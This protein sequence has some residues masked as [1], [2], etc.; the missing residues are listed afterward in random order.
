MSAETNKC[1]AKN[2]ILGAASETLTRNTNNVNGGHEIQWIDMLRV[3]GLLP[4]CAR[5]LGVLKAQ[6]STKLKHV[7]GESERKEGRW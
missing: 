4:V 2:A 6:S 5:A 1:H 7:G 3:A